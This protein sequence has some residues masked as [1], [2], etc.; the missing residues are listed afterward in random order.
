M[1][2]ASRARRLRQLL[3]GPEIVVVPGAAD[4]ITARIIEDAGFPAAYATGAGFANASFAVPDV[5][6]VSVTDVID[7]V[8]RMTDSIDIPLLVDADTGYG[9]VLNVYRTVRQLER[10]GAA[11]IQIEDQAD[12]KRCGHFDGQL[13]VPVRTMLG[14]LAAALDAR[15]DPDVLIVARTDARESEGFTAAIERAQAYAEAG[16]DVIFLE[17]PRT[18]DE[19]AAVPGQIPVP[20]LANIVEGG[21]TPELPAQELQNLGFKV[22]LFANTALRVGIRAVESAMSTLRAEG[23][24][25]SLIQD[26]VTWEERQQLIGLAAAQAQENRY[27]GAAVS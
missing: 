1:T 27:Y 19:L 6:L 7:H 17:A 9:G 16:A 4:A 8:R 18:V 22:A 5:G 21:K 3:D 25:Q 24:T 23:S 2:T 12:P 13:V 26:M 20:C 10:A 14:K 15:T 11:A